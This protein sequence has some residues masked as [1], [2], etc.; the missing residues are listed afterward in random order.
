M[1]A[2]DAQPTYDCSASP[3]IGR[4]S[5]ILNLTLTNLIHSANGIKPA[6]VSQRDR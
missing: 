3:Q 6:V 5:P 2:V 4:D 1:Q